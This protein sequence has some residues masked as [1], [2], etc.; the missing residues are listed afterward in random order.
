MAEPAW[1]ARIRDGGEKR[2]QT[3]IDARLLAEIR[4]LA[5]EQG[6]SEQEVLEDAVRYF[7]LSRAVFAKTTE[8][9]ADPEDAERWNV[10]SIKELF[11]EI[12]R[13]QREHGV[14]RLSDEEALR[15][16]VEEQHAMRRE[17]TSR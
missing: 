12:E 6:R 5:G 4:K 8:R 1:R 7:L 11:A 17:R 10:G 2:L 14:E 16:A 9:S 15:L 13:W 3:E